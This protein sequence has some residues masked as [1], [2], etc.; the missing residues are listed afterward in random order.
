MTNLKKCAKMSEIFIYIFSTTIGNKILWRT[1]FCDP[2]VK[3][4]VD[5]ILR[6]ILRCRNSDYIMAKGVNYDKDI[7]IILRWRRNWAFCIH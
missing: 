6:I 1:K 5:C 4:S 3:K 7:L 2:M